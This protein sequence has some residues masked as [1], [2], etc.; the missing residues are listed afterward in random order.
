MKFAK[1]RSLIAAS[2]AL[3]LVPGII[4]AAPANAVEIE[5]QGNCSMGSIF[6]AE[7]E[8]EFNV[9]DLSFDVDTKEL[10]STWRLIVNQNGTRVSKTR[11]EAVKDFDDSYA[12]V[13]WNLIRPDR[14]G[15]DRFFM[16]AKNLS[17]GEICKVVLRG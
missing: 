10:N 14:A 1:P 17:S 4:L 2:L 3:A 5:R 13:E 7:I 11:A 9:W 12:E 15:T 8:K 16:S 6:S